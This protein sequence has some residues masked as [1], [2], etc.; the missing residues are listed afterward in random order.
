MLSYQYNFDRMYERSIN[1][2]NLC[3]IKV[4]SNYERFTQ[5]RMIPCM[6]FLMFYFYSCYHGFL[7]D[8]RTQPPTKESPVFSQG[9]LNILFTLLAEEKQFRHQLAEKVQ[10]LQN[11]LLDTQKS[12]TQIYHSVHNKSTV[13]ESDDNSLAL[14]NSSFLHVQQDQKFLKSQFNQQQHDLALFKLEF[15][16]LKLNFIALQKTFNSVRT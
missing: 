12:V 6:V 9:R 3:S 16:Q 15:N 7:L 1:K 4:K 2:L 10:K 5:F 8:D 11:E 14:S 13:V